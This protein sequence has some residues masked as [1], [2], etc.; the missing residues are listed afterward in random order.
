MKIIVFS[1]FLFSS[2]TAQL[3]YGF[4]F[5]KVGSAGFQ[6]L[7]IDVGAGPTGFGGAATSIVNDGLGVYWNIAGIA[8]IK[9]YHFSVSENEWLV[10]SKVQTA[11][12]AKRFNNNVVAVNLMTYRINPFEE[13]TVQEPY[14]TGRMVNAGND[15]IGLAL[16]R[17]FT[18]K[19][20]LGF[21]IKYVNEI[22]DDYSYSNLMLDVG[23]LYKTG[24]RDI[25]LAFVFQNFGPDIS[26]INKKFRT[27]LVFKI[28]ASDTFFK[29]NAILSKIGIDLIHPIDGNELINVGVENSIFNIFQIRI[30]NQFNRDL[31]N[32]SYGIGLKDIKLYDGIYYNVD[33]SYSIINDIFGDLHR[34]SMGFNY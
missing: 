10:D 9:N 23:S 11:V 32:L 3:D 31:V 33:Y 12:F 16:A 4:D 27:P 18:D 19:L 28:G 29:S 21:Q 13:T 1:I 7:K 6:F 25:K 26:P 15:L 5:S 20:K 24:F 17:N 22:L 2:L 34:I 8:D 30:G 14:G